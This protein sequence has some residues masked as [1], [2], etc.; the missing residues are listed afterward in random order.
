MTANKTLTAKILI[1]CCKNPDRAKAICG[2]D[3]SY[4]FQAYEFSNGLI[5]IP[6]EITNDWFFE[7]RDSIEACGK[8]LVTSVEETD[9][10]I[11]L[12]TKSLLESIQGSMRQFGK[13]SVPP[14]HAELWWRNK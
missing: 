11:A 14:K 9:S 7:D 4:T 1:V 13:N 2:Y 10:S 3:L 6:E 5:M 12:S 8:D